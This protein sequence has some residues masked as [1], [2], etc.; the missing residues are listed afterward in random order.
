MEPNRLLPREQTRLHLPVSA[1]R[2][3]VAVDVVTD[4]AMAV[5]VDVIVTVRGTQAAQETRIGAV[6]AIVVAD[7]APCRAPICLPSAIC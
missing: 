2:A 6:A 4:A 7:A 1:A 3:I 5:V